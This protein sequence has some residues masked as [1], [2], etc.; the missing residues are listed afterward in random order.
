MFSLPGTPGVQVDVPGTDVP[1]ARAEIQ[2]GTAYVTLDKTGLTPVQISQAAKAAFEA[3]GVN[4][5]PFANGYRHAV[6]GQ[7]AMFSQKVSQ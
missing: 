1:V 4:A 2:N 7:W 5:D 3:L 6:S